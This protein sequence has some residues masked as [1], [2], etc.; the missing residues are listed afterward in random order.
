MAKLDRF[1]LEAEREGD[2]ISKMMPMRPDRM[3]KRIRKIRDMHT[4]GHL[5]HH[6][7]AVK[8]VLH[9]G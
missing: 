3:G 6:N 8:R 1:D 9:N 5:K 7:R 2:A 4:K